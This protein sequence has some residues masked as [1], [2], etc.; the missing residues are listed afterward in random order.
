MNQPKP[1]PQTERETRFPL[2]EVAKLVLLGRSG[3][4]KKITFRFKGGNIIE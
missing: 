4:L 3:S 2:K 1:R